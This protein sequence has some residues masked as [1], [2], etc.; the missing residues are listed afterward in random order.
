MTA[1]NHLKRYPNARPSTVAYLMRR[2][3]VT[4]QLRKETA[5]PKRPWW[6]FWRAK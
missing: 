1:T 3:A 2:D 4:E 6:M 5:K